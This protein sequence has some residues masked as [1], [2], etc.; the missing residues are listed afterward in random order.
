M[1][2]MIE[3]LKV[4]RNCPVCNSPDTFIY[5]MT[6]Y[7]KIHET[8]TEKVKIHFY[9]QCNDCDSKYRITQRCLI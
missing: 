9:I 7:Q 3:D 1:K 8:G 6:K 5:K 2:E 4:I